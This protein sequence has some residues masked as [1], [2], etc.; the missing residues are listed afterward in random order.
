MGNR[1]I[2]TL[3]DTGDGVADDGYVL[4]D[5]VTGERVDIDS[6]SSNTWP[7]GAFS[8]ECCG[9]AEFVH[10]RQDGAI[11]IAT[12]EDHIRVWYPPEHTFETVSVNLMS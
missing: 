7:V 10:V 8:E 1:A 6:E 2:M 11:V 3:D 5:L 4:V 9:G 12:N